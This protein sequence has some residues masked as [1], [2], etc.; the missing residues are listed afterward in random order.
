MCHGQLFAFD[1]AAWSWRTTARVSYGSGRM[2]RRETC[3]AC[4]EHRVQ[5]LQIRWKREGKPESLND[6]QMQIGQDVELQPGAPLR[7]YYGGW[8]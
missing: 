6:P 4:P 5:F 2:A 1:P 7:T 8:G 3:R